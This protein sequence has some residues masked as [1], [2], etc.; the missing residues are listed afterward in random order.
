LLNAG[1]ADEP[2]VPAPGQPRAIL[3]VE[4]DVVTRYLIADALRHVG[5]KVLEAASATEALAILKGVCIDLLFVDVHMPGEGDGLSVARFARQHQPEA[6]IIVTSGKVKAP[7]L[8]EIKALGPFIAKPYLISRVIM[9]VQ[10]A[11]DDEGGTSG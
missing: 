2:T 7:D 9:L 1:A 3:V 5:Y 10:A 6:R 4:D 11:L 8:P